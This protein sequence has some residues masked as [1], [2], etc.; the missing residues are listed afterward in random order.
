MCSIFVKYLGEKLVRRCSFR[1]D[2]PFF[3]IKTRKAARTEYSPL[4]ECSIN[5]NF[6][7][8]PFVIEF[9]SD[10]NEKND[11]RG[12]G[13]ENEIPFSNACRNFETRYYIDIYSETL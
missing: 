4:S 9:R 13:N 10:E 2:V 12:S 11:P 7:R 3:L 6:Q 5:A 8:V 1:N